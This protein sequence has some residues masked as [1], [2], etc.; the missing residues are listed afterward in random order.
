MLAARHE[1]GGKDADQHHG[2]PDPCGT[3]TL[4]AIH[5]PSAIAVRSRELDAC[6]SLTIPLYGFD[7]PTYSQWRTAS[8]DVV[9]D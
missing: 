8:A 4:H 6:M 9:T 3:P 7:Q 5:E 2:S 1:V